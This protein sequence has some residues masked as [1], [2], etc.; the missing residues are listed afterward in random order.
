VIT[1]ASSQGPFTLE[2]EFRGY[3]LFRYVADNQP[4]E[5]RYFRRGETFRMD[6]RSEIRMWYS[7]SGSLRARISGNEI[8]FGKPGE[9]G[10]AVIRWVRAETGR[11]YRL[12][13][14]PM[15]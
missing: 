5:E 2:A 14:I 10:A 8:E 13:V 11:G 15:Y 9:V 4:R 1:E 7:N 12:E 3:C 6:V